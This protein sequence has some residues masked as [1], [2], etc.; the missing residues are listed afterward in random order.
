[1]SFLNFLGRVKPS[2]DVVTSKTN[3]TNNKAPDGVYKGVN[4]SAIF[5]SD[6]FTPGND[7]YILFIKRDPTNVAAMSKDDKAAKRIALYMPPQIAV[8]YGAQWEEIQMTVYQY[9]DTGKAI[10]DNAQELIAGSDASA[11]KASNASIYGMGKA[12][13]AALDYTAGGQNF[14]GQFE[15]ITKKTPNPH[16]AMMFKGVDFRQFG[17]TFQMMARNADETE[18]IREIIKSFKAGMHPDVEQAEGKYWIY[19]DSFDIYLS[20]GLPG[21]EGPSKYL[22]QISTAVL[23]SMSVDYA[24]SGIPSFF[25]S[26]GAP[27]DIRMTLQ[28]KELDILTREKIHQGY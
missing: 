6:L 19:P 23:Q 10:W 18:A 14:S 7:S 12:A 20:T 13:I 15:Q 9:A 1:M 17:F 16:M 21:A 8:N 26:N 4:D 28:F 22:F 3:L 5:P 27:V 11:L 24:G 25:E 2:D